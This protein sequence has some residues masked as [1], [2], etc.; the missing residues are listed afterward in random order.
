M[1]NAALTSLPHRHLQSSL[2]HWNILD[3]PTLS[4]YSWQQGH[5]LVDNDSDANI[6]WD[7]RIPDAECLVALNNNTLIEIS[8]L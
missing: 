3:L 2:E 1:L 7:F 6:I 8:H 4:L 5:I